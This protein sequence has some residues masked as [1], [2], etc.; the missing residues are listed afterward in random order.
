MRTLILLS[1]FFG[2]T[3]WANLTGSW[4]GQGEWNF[5]GSGDHCYFQMKFHESSTE[6]VR[7]SGS[8][9]CSVV[10]T[11]IPAATWTKQD[12]QLI[13]DGQVVGSETD[14]QILLHEFEEG[15]RAVDVRMDLKGTRFEYQEIWYDSNHQVLY[16]IH[17][18]LFGGD[19]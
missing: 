15:G 7:E 5:Q 12:G 10:G 13:S 16:D 4:I 11:E 3:A 6:L 14:S 17:G 19:Q 1:V 9:D 2:T 8:I 18:T